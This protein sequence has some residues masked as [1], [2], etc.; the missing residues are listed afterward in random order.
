MAATSGCSLFGRDEPPMADAGASAP[1]ISPEVERRPIRT[2]KIDT[3]DF[4]ITAYYGMISVEDFGSNPIY[5][6]RVAYH[7]SEGL[8]L[9]GT[10]AMA[11][12]VD[13]SSVE[14]L[15]NIDLLGS[16]RDYS[17]YD[18]AIG[19]NLLPG[20]VFLGKNHAFNSALYV[21]GGAGNTSFADE[22]LF[23]LTFGAGYRVLATDSIALHF[24][25]RD[26]LFDNDVTGEDKTTH[27]IEFNLGVS[28]FF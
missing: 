7:V 18:L 10:Y 3:E 17:Y 14:V 16:D 21:I 11:G 2:P 25:V 26:H 13:R 6:A 5:G 24:D 9:E 20:E 27:N 19:W 28:W 15:S 22:D 12:D 23:T 8:F 4:E 1:V